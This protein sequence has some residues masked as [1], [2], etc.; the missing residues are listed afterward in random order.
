MVPAETTRW[1]HYLRTVRNRLV[2][3]L[4][5]ALT[6]AAPALVGVETSLGSTSLPS[7]GIFRC[8]HVVVDTDCFKAIATNVKKKGGG[9]KVKGLRVTNGNGSPC[10]KIADVCLILHNETNGLPGAQVDSTEVTKY[11]QDL[12]QTPPDPPPGP[13]QVTDTICATVAVPS[14]EVT[15]ASFS[16]NSDQG[17]TAARWELRSTDENG[18]EN[19]MSGTF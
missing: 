13:D 19:T 3:G 7:A 17:V 5:V 8:D 1:M 11:Y 2:A 4:G 18:G 9:V 14:E 16:N 6:T 12:G 15:I 10:P